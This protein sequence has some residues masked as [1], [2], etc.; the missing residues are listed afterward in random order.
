MPAPGEPL[1]ERARMYSEH[2]VEGLDVGQVTTHDMEVIAQAIAVAFVVGHAAA[3]DDA[4][5]VSALG[6][7]GERRARAARAAGKARK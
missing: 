3:L 7:A 1:A 2:V 5:P 6:G 4:S